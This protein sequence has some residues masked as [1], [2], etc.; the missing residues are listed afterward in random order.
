M[1]SLLSLMTSENPN[2][3]IFEALDTYKTP[4]DKYVPPEI[5]EMQKKDNVKLRNNLFRQSIQDNVIPKDHVNY[6]KALKAD[7]F[8]PRVIYDIGSCLLHWTKEARKIW[9]DAKIIAFDASTSVEFLYNKTQVDGY[10][11][12]VL[13]D[14]DDKELTFYQHDA[15]QGG[16]SYYK[17]IGSKNSST[18]FNKHTAYTRRGMTLDTIVAEREFPLPDLIK[19]DVQG[20]EKDVVGGGIKT[21][22]NCKHLI[23]EMQRE[24]YNERSAAC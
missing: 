9:P 6:L 8:E 11:I 13:T 15:Y 24:Q 23:V 3:G 12:G 20:A 7:G 2:I 16:N 21:L 4:K 22:Q 19:I 10:N 5:L 18:L 14:E 1:S 17:E